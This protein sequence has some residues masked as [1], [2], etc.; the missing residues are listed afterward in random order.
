MSDWSRVRAA[1]ADAYRMEIDMFNGSHEDALSA[2]TNAAFSAL[3]GDP[4]SANYSKDY[5]GAD[6]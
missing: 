2:A 3:Y 1:M 4:D 6:E 5:A